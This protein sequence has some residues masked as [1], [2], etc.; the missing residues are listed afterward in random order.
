MNDDVKKCCL[1]IYLEINLIKI[2]YFLMQSV[3]FKNYLISLKKSLFDVIIN[4]NLILLK[5]NIIL[6]NL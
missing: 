3:H 1:E 2:F 5:N 4:I 6:R